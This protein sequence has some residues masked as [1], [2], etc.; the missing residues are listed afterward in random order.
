MDGWRSTV[1]NKESVIS[2]TEDRRGLTWKR[3]HVGTTCLSFIWSALLF[4]A[5]FHAAC[6][7][8]SVIARA[9]MFSDLLMK[10]RSVET[11]VFS[12]IL[13]SWNLGLCCGINWNGS[14]WTPNVISVIQSL[15]DREDGAADRFIQRQSRLI[16][17]VLPLK[18]QDVFY[19]VS[20]CR[21]SL[22]VDLADTKAAD[23]L[24]S[25]KISL[26]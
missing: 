25:V 3:W 26:S 9:S 22:H 20:A 2:P 11:A 24:H 16:G 13:R 23:I 19:K 5:Q 12:R 4:A 15:A 1:C 18:K 10:L 8:Q 6:P 14:G 21:A 17:F 7:E